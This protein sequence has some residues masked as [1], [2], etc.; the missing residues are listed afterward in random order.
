MKPDSEFEKLL[1]TT[2]TTGTV[3]LVIGV[4]RG[5]IQEKHGNFMTFFR[6]V[7]ASVTVAVLVGWGLSETSL[8]LTSQ[9]CIV[10]VCSYLA[11]DVLLGLLVL[12]RLFR[13][14]PGSFFSKFYDAIR[15]RSIL[16][17]KILDPSNDVAPPKKDGEA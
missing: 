3:A 1:V 17:T 2:S 15:G 16:T 6:G 14:D 13:E 10:G 11:D 7:L 8:S 12:G 9:M 4:F 5:I